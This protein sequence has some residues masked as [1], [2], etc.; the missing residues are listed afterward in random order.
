MSEP[1]NGGQGRDRGGEKAGK[2]KEERMEEEWR[3][4]GQGG[5]RKEEN[6]Q[7][8]RTNERILRK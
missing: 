8:L 5:S 2:R 1:G 7:G 6:Q 4:S 3:R